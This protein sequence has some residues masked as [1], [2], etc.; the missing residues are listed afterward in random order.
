MSYLLIENQYFGSVNYYR[1]LFQY[2]DV[3]IESFEAFQKM[4]FRNRCTIVGSGGPIQLTIPLV[5]GRNNKQLIRDVRINYSTQWQQQHW[6]TIVSCYGRSPFFEYYRDEV[7]QFYKKPV[8]FLWDFNWSI[9]Q[10]MVK[11]LKCTA[12]LAVSDVYIKEVPEGVFD[13]RNIFLP[14]TIAQFSAIAYTQVFEHSIGFSPNASVLDLLFC[15]GP[16]AGK[17]LKC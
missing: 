1:T 2:K 15:E 13:A 6:R 14:A 10:W 4:S 7:A 12:S 3:K 16:S 5:G 8:T 17:L 11:Q 9:L